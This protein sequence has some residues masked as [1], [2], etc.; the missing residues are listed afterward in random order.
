MDFKS[1]FKGKMTI[2]NKDGVIGM[3]N[4]PSIPIVKN[5]QYVASKDEQ[6]PI[7][8]NL[9]QYTEGIRETKSHIFTNIQTSPSKRILT[10]YT[11]KFSKA[12]S[13]VIKQHHVK[14][15][16]HYYFDDPKRQLNELRMQQDFNQLDMD[17]YE[18]V[19]IPKKMLGQLRQQMSVDKYGLTKSF[20][21]DKKSPVELSQ[22][23]PQITTK[24]TSYNQ[25]PLL[26]K[27]NTF[28]QVV[29]PSPFIKQRSEKV[30]K[31][32]Q[33]I[34]QAGIGTLRY[35]SYSKR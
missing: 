31:K 16:H 17:E 3:V 6:S 35:N 9:G 21:I 14:T 12:G 8:Q 20:R 29:K 32:N 5:N 28:D 22:L 18:I 15:E 2:M 19:A 11:Q 27:Q 13:Q 4:K 24:C 25:T 30:E 1:R 7:L 33:I 10:N 34:Q 26:R 23:S